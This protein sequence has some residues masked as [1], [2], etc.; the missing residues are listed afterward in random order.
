MSEAA[1][2]LKVAGKTYRVV[3]T[4]AEAELC[5]LAE[6]VEDALEGVVPPGREASPQA[7]VLAAITL[8]HELEQERARRIEAETR[9]KLV[10]SRLLARVDQALLETG[11]FEAETEGEPALVFARSGRESSSASREPRER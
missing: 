11:P 4:A 9:H 5:R 8:A 7:L 1:V 6:K 3:T 2:Q 10:L